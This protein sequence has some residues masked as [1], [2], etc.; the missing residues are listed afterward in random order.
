MKFLGHIFRII[1]ATAIIGTVLYHFNTQFQ[2]AIDQKYEWLFPCKTPITYSLGT[3]DPKFGISKDDFLTAVKAGEKTW[4]DAL[5][6]KNLLEYIPENGKVTVN[7]I[8][9]ERQTATDKLKKLGYVINND[10]AGFSDLKAKYDALS[11]TF[12]QTKAQIANDITDLKRDQAAYEKEVAHWNSL[13]GAPKDEFAKLQKEKNDLNSRADNINQRQ[14][15]LNQS[16]DTVNSLG[17]V[18]NEQIDTLNLDVQKYNNNQQTLGDEFDQGEYILDQS[19]RSINIYQYDNK[20]KLERVLAHE[21][22]HAIGLG[23]NDNPKSVMYKLDQG[24]TLTLSAED[25]A[26]LKAVCHTL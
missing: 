26:A 17:T 11:K 21:L 18:L 23:H 13:G 7:L 20:A 15:T 6:G 2:T 12:N 9:D 25:I 1:I 16:V 24:T 19:G 10:K 14:N 22:G 3:V 4:E 5:N 8:Y